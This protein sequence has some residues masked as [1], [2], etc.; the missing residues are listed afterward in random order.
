V[1]IRILTEF[2]KISMPEPLNF[3]FIIFVKTHKVILR[4]LTGFNEK[5]Y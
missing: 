3:F 5:L 1:L 4:I 2:T